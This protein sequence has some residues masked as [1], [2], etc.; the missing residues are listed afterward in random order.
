[1]P[2]KLQIN[3]VNLAFALVALAG[4]AQFVF[5]VRLCMEHYPGGYRWGSHFVSDLGRTQTVAGADNSA[6]SHTFSRTTAVLGISLLPFMVTFPGLFAHGKYLLRILGFLSSIGLIGI[7][8]TPYDKYVELH[9]IWLGIW[10]VPMAAMVFLLPLVL[11]MEAA[12]PESLIFLSAL[13]LL[14][15]ALYGIAGFRTGYVIMQKIVILLSMVWLTVVA[16]SATIAATNVQS[17][18]QQ[19]LADQAA[20]YSKRLERRRRTMP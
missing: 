17:D 2:Q 19:L 8:Q 11:K 18:R 10:V 20:W 9:H 4:V 5:C 1:M 6:V 15:T 3:Y 7:G 16:A 14:A 12:A 13:L